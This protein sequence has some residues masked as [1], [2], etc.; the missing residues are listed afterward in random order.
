MIIWS[1]WGIL[2]PLIFILGTVPVTLGIEALMRALNGQPGGTVPLGF[3]LLGGAALN[4]VVGRKLNSA[5]G[6]D[7]VDPANGEVVRLRRS[8][9]LFFIKM[10]WWSILAAVLA[11]VWI[12]SGL[13]ARG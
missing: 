5:P 7:L 10:E 12:V 4:W 2:T 1:G 8:H 6:R 13:L 9:S 3:G 11:V